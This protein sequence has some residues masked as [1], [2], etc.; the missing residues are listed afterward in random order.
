M[1]MIDL[2]AISTM[3]I[4]FFEV[5]I[6]TSLDYLRHKKAAAIKKKGKDFSF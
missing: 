6:H 3:S 4:P 1:K 5:I 2:W